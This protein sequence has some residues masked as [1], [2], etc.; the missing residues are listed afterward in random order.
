MKVHIYFDY[1]WADA[2]ESGNIGTSTFQFA[3]TVNV[4]ALPRVGDVID[5]FPDLDDCIVEPVVRQGTVESVHWT[6]TFNKEGQ[7]VLQANIFLQDINDESVE[8]V[9]SSRIRDVLIERG[10][11][12]NYM[13]SKDIEKGIVTQGQRGGLQFY[14]TTYQT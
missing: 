4:P 7:A 9:K 5:F 11:D 1:T 3:T 14:R 2:D 10:R 13:A 8:Y 6:P 12:K